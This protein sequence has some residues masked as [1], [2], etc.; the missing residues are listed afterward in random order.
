MSK[1][2]S[3]SKEG[4]LTQPYE[5][6][7]NNRLPVDTKCVITNEEENRCLVK[8]PGIIGYSGTYGI[9][10]SYVKEVKA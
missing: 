10:K 5:A 4:V 3:G 8:F 6:F 1:P 9:K 2:A 7:H